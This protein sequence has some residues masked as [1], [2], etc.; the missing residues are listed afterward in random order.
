MTVAA[1]VTPAEELPAPRVTARARAEAAVETVSAG[2][3]TSSRPVSPSLVAG[4][5]RRHRVPAPAASRTRDSQGPREPDR[6]AGTALSALPPTA[7]AAAGAG[8]TTEE[9]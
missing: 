5:V 2:Q 4:R 6:S 8:A 9:A 1:E 3:A 7:V